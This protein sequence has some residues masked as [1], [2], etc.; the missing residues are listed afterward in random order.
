MRFVMMLLRL[1]R[2]S[3][4]VSRREARNRRRGGF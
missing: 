1:L 2:I 4:R 3:E